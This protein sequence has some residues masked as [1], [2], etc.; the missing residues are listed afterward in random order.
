M[1][2]INLFSFFLFLT[3][4]IVS[5]G[6]KATIFAYLL[7]YLF[8]ASPQKNLFIFNWRKIAS[9]YRVDLCIHQH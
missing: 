4:H 8:F 3:N 2:L 9:Q 7:F 1:N 5:L 6:I